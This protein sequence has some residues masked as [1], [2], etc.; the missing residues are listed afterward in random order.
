MEKSN[1]LLL[2]FTIPDALARDIFLIDPAP[3]I[4]TH[5]FA[6][7][8][9]RALK[10]GFGDVVLAS[11]CPIQNYP[12][13]PKIIF[14]GKCFE[15]HEVKGVLLGFINLLVLKHL[16]RFVICLLT[17]PRLLASYKVGW[18]FIHG[19]HTP[20]LIFGLLAKLFGKKLV[21]VLTDPPG[22][23][24]PTDGLIARV[25]KRFDIWFVGRALGRT[26]AVIALAPEL[27]KR[28]VVH[29][30]NLV[31]PGIIDSTIFNDIPKIGPRVYCSGPFT[32]VY[33]G[34]LN[35]IYG[36]DRLLD[37]ILGFE[38][39]VVRL[40]LFGLGDQV[41]RIMELIANDDRFL[42]GGFVGNDELI[43][44]LYNADL[45]I[46][47]RP[48]HEDFSMM[49]FPSKLIEYLAVGRPVLTT[50]IAS[51]PK[52]YQSH[53][54]FIDDE[55]SEGIRSAILTVMAKSADDREAHSMRAQE[56]IYAEASEVAIGKKVAEL[57]CSVNLNH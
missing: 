43:P 18:I 42:Y 41:P 53:F 12:L 19:V 3:A 5:K 26:D 35:K 8:L 13:S 47:P 54:F 1:V 6:W 36:V 46:N 27:I 14:R 57:V 28:F 4:Q 25:L 51:I 24:L 39:G 2:G 45:L 38:V 15:E 52:S 56:F 50:R 30:R 11:V 10:S 44:E 33:A 16:S 31:F 48:T 29:E 22:I 17:V 40:K 9:A 20:F 21:V 23:Q 49:S 37:A 34:G 32:I 55:S 7:S